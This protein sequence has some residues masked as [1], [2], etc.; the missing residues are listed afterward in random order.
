[1]KEYIEEIEQNI[2]NIRSAIENQGVDIPENTPL[3]EYADKIAEI[4]K[5]TVKIGHDILPF[6]CYADNE[7]DA[8]TNKS[9]PTIKWNPKKATW[10]ITEYED[11]WTQSIPNDNPN[12]LLYAMFVPIKEGQNSSDDTF[13]WPKAIRLQGKK[14]EKGEEGNDGRDGVI[15]GMIQYLAA[16]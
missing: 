12:K 5:P 1:M 13:A 16:H 14:G 9:K 4:E 2:K 6:Y 8:S 11:G 10:D 7:V 15:A 3:D